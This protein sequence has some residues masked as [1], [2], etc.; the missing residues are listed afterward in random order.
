MDLLLKLDIHL[1]VHIIELLKNIIEFKL[2]A[3]NKLSIITYTP[4]IKSIT[5]EEFIIWLQYDSIKDIYNVFNKLKDN[6]CDE[7]YHFIN[8]YN[9]E[10]IDL[11]QNYISSKGDIY[12]LL[13]SIELYLLYNK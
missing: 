5:N 12:N 8:Y 3:G 13:N 11:I 6:N 9:E 2:D 10:Y 1:S 4:T 7:C